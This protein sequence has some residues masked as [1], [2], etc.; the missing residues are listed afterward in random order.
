MRCQYLPP[1][2]D[3]TAITSPCDRQAFT[4]KLYSR[5]TSLVPHIPEPTSP[6][7]A[8]RSQLRLFRRIPCHSLN[9]TRVPSQLRAILHL[10]L[11]RIPDPQCAICGSRRYEM[12]GGVPGY[13]ANAVA[14]VLCWLEVALRM[15]REDVRVRAWAARSWVVVGLRFKSRKEGGEAIFGDG[16][17]RMRCGHALVM[18]SGMMRKWS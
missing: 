15:V 1:N 16:S 12:A 18:V 7:T 13:C 11:F 8:H 14:G 5:R 17:S 9:R 6:I 10:W 3:Y 2:H 4:P